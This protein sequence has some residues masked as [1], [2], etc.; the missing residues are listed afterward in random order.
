MYYLGVDVLVLHEPPRD[1]RAD[2]DGSHVER[3][4]LLPD[5]LEARAVPVLGFF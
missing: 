1:V 2:G 5:L 4:V 3:A